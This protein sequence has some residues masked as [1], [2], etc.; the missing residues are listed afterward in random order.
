[1]SL[2]IWDENCSYWQNLIKKLQKAAPAIRLQLPLERGQHKKKIL[3]AFLVWEHLGI[4][5]FH[6]EK[7]VQKIQN[8]TRNSCSREGMKVIWFSLLYLCSCELI[9]FGRAECSLWESKGVNP[10][11]LKPD[12]R[13]WE[14]QTSLKAILVTLGCFQG[15]HQRALSHQ[16]QYVTPLVTPAMRPIS[17]VVRN[18]LRGQ[19]DEELPF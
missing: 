17:V 10:Q 6:T 12:C 18:D 19:T 9:E 1:M 13:A 2:L 15:W 5:L 11:F 14:V 8:R 16:P 4:A 3:C 7:K